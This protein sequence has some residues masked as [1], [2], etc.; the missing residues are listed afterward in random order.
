MVGEVNTVGLADAVRTRLFARPA[1][2]RWLNH[3]FGAIFAALAAR[4]AME[5]A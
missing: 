3:S 1:I 5:R 2:L 4:L